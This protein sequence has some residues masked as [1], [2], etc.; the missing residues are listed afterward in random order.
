MEKLLLPQLELIYSG[1]TIEVLE[2][3]QDVY[4]VISK[5]S[6]NLCITITLLSEKHGQI[7]D[8]WDSRSFKRYQN[9][10]KYENN[11]ISRWIFVLHNSVTDVQGNKITLALLDGMDRSITL[12]HAEHISFMT[13]EHVRLYDYEKTNKGD[14]VKSSKVY[15]LLTGE[16]VF[17]FD[18]VSSY[19]RS[20]Y[21]TNVCRRLDT[22]KN[23]YSKHFFVDRHMKV[24]TNEQFLATQYKDTLNSYICQTLNPKEFKLIGEGGI[25]LIKDTFTGL[26]INGDMVSIQK[27]NG[28]VLLLGVQEI[29]NQSVKNYLHFERKTYGY[30]MLT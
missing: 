26:T 12:P 2:D 18:I 14:I 4:Y 29:A 6:K 3:L 15:S 16:Q 22:T 8:N 25:P 30:T 19:G 7:L 9:H 10:Y 28:G 11:V 23:R 20:R 27:S 24:L 5:D 21:L 17:N 1:C 13:P